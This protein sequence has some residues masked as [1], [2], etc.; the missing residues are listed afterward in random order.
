MRRLASP[1]SAGRRSALATLLLIGTVDIP[2]ESQIHTRSRLQTRWSF[3]LVG[4]FTAVGMVV[5]R[6]VIRATRSDGC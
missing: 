4:P 1:D 6:G 2:L 3:S 5:A